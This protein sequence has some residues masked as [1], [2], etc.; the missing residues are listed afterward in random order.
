MTSSPSL[1][2]RVDVQRPA[3][4]LDPKAEDSQQ[5]HK[6]PAPDNSNMKPDTARANDKMSSVASKY[7][8]MLDGSMDEEITGPLELS[9]RGIHIPTRTR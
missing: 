4:P 7:M 9:K 6:T 5:R 1:V 2:P 3:G 8:A